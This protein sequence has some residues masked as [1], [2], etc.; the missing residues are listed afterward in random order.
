MLTS[1]LFRADAVAREVSAVHSEFVQ[2]R[3]PR[4]G[5]QTR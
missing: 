2:V 1:P 3:T 4:A 5:R